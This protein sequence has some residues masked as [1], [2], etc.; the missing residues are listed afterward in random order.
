L[1]V[2]A[3]DPVFDV[4]GLLVG[5]WAGHALQEADGPEIDVLLEAP[6]DR[7]EQAP[8][9]DMVGDSGPADRAQIDRIEA[10]QLLDAVL[11]HEFAALEIAVAAPIEMRPVERKTVLLRRRFEHALPLGH[12]LLADAVAR[13]DGDLVLLHA[14]ISLRARDK[15]FHRS[16]GVGEK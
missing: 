10:T 15:K 16:R 3:H 4:A 5:E 12:D 11:R 6:P 7:N 1:A 9:R 14:E 13:D 2:L 8:E